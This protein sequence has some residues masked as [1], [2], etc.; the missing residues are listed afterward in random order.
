[1]LKMRYRQRIYYTDEQKKMMWDRWQKGESLN[2]IARHFGRFAVDLQRNLSQ[3]R[4]FLA[5]SE[6]GVP[7]ASWSIEKIAIRLA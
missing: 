1:M 3:R 2:S 6:N 7:V 5:A 4:S